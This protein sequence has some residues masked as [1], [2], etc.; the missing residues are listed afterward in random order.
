MSSKIIPSKASLA[1]ALILGLLMLGFGIQTIMEAISGDGSLFLGL[2]L[3]LIVL[4]IAIV[5]LLIIP[6]SFIKFGENQ[7]TKGN[8]L[9]KKTLNLDDVKDMEFERHPRMGNLTKI[10]IHKTNDETFEISP[11]L[12]EDDKINEILAF[13]SDYFKDPVDTDRQ[14]DDM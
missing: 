3:G 4:I 9:I 8:L 14:I 2:F 1:G 10:R 6:T 7:I 5:S 12:F 13:L 11:T